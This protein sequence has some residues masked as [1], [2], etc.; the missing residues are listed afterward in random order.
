MESSYHESVM[1]KEVLESLH[2]NKGSLYID[3][4]LGTGGHA[5][6]IIKAGG[7][8]FGIEADPEIL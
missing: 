7:K 3:A 2:V 4:T 8:I 5:L 1:V 6:E